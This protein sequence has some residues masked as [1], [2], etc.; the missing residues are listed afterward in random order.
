MRRCAVLATALL[1]VLWA[2]AIPAGEARGEVL[3]GIADQ[4]AETFSD[5]RMHALGMGRARIAVSWDVL[6]IDYERERLDR[7]VAAALRSGVQ[8]LISFQH[9]ARE[10]RSLPSPVGFTEQFLAVRKRYPQVT[11]FATWNEAN[12]CGEPTCHRPELVAAYWRK[13]SL[14]CR[15]CTV[16]AAEVLD[17]K[18]MSRWILDFRAHTRRKY[19]G[20]AREPAFWGLHNYVD[21]NRF[22]TIGTRRMRA[23]TRGQIWLTE[24]G[25]IVSR[26]NRSDLDLPRGPRHAARATKFLLERLVPQTRR[27]R[28]LYLYHWQVDDLQGTWDSGLITPAGNERP[29]YDVL[30][31]WVA[32][33]RAREGERG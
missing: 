23:H 29:A 25:G 11:Q 20:A 6:E 8:P 26:N 15:E 4:K 14:A 24:V 33:R 17:M 5:P 30:A 21:A 27:I 3:L 2:A 7:W 9:S 12:H 13:L 22:R 18:N 10:R 28:R 32:A 19:R 31:A 16:L 1:A